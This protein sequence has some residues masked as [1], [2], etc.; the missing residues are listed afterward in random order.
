L[1]QKYSIKML[2]F[3]TDVSMNDS[4][5]SKFMKTEST[6]P[7]VACENIPSTK[8]AIRPQS[9]PAWTT[10]ERH[11]SYE[12]ELTSTP[13]VRASEVAR[14]RALIADPNYPS[15]EQL[16]KIARVLLAGGLSR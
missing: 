5:V 2:K 14:G 9:G 13:D 3:G 11:R 10:F 15:R 8:R 1:F 16:G 4:E 7:A 6:V 12:V